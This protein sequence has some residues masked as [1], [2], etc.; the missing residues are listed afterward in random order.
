MV[1]SRTPGKQINPLQRA[2]GIV[3][4]TDVQGGIFG[5]GWGR[6]GGEGSVNVGVDD[7][8][9]TFGTIGRGHEMWVIEHVEMGVVSGDVYA[10]IAGII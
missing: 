10:H 9:R 4:E 3:L 5:D 8:R 7:L 6:R 1:N 2:Q